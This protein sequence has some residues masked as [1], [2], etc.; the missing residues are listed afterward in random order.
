M[1]Y[2][3]INIGLTLTNM[4]GTLAV[5]LYVRSDARD[6]AANT[7]LRKLEDATN[8]RFNDKCARL[9]RLE[10]EVKA[11]PT[12]Q[13]FDEQVVRLHQRIDE[14]NGNTRNTHLMLGELMGYVKQENHRRRHDD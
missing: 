8:H 5:W 4:V 7:A 13:Q 3:A 2:Q 6:Q 12:R 9:A 10:A 1:D 14:I 11:M